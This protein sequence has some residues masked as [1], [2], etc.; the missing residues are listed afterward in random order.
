[1]SLSSVKKRVF[2]ILNVAEDGDYV[3]LAFDIFIFSV[4]VLNVA[5]LIL[6]SI[7]SVLEKYWLIFLLISLFTMIIF[8][9]EYV[10]RIWSCTSDPRYSEPFKGRIRWALTP[11]ALIDLLVILPYFAFLFF[12][13]DLTALVILRIFRLL[14]VIKYSDSLSLVVRVIK[15]ER[16]TLFTT[17]AAL[18][19]VLLVAGTLMYQVEGSAQPEKFASIPDGMWWG[20]ITLA[21]IGY[22]DVVPITAAGKLLGSIIALIGIGLFALPAGILAS[23]FSR[24]IE[25]VHK[26]EK[27]EEIYLCPHCRQEVTKKDLW[28]K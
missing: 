17:Y 27:D 15:N 25:S 18:I 10:L 22:G 7:R 19:M 8:I 5:V 14:K 23:G 1:M 26:A 21:T 20:V 4:I 16:K 3:S 2:E 6:G 13:V 11:F 24:E 12:G 28:K 9:I